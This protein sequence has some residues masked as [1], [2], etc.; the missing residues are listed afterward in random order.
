MQDNLTE[1]LNKFNKVMEN[2][3]ERDKK[4]KDL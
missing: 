3:K 2:V 4:L 1:G